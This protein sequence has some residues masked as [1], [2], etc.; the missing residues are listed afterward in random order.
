MLTITKTHQG[1]SSD[2]FKISKLSSSNSSPPTTLGDY[3]CLLETLIIRTCYV[4]T[5]ISLKVTNKN[6]HLTLIADENDLL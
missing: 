6:H 2:H 1:E 4:T 3:C 5:Q